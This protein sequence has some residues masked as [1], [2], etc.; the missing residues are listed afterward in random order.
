MII[1]TVTCINTKIYI[2]FHESVGDPDNKEA[3]LSWML[4]KDL[5]ILTEK[6]T[7]KCLFGVM[8]RG[9]NYIVP[10]PYYL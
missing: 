4:Y 5:K 6:I 1:T 10:I 3:N 7:S 9:T 8:V 2:G